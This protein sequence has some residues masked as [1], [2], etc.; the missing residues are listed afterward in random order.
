MGVESQGYTPP[1]PEDEIKTEGQV[2]EFP[3]AK[4]DESKPKPVEQQIREAT[5]DR[6][7]EGDYSVPEWV[8]DS[9]GAGAH[10]EVDPT[11]EF[12]AEKEKEM[13]KSVDDGWENIK[14]KEFNLPE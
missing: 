4:V 14:S 6:I 12:Q 5:H 9:K 10:F 3:G 1:K 7:A 13:K 11:V 8:T 2:I